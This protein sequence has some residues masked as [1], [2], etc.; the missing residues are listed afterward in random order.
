MCRKK[1]SE[2]KTAM[3]FAL[4]PWV[5]VKVKEGPTDENMP[6]ISFW[7]VEAIC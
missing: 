1:T 5:P 2:R 7:K 4:C 6:V 3:S